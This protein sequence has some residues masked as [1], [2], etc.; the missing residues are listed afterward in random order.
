MSTGDTD[1]IWCANNS[2]FISSRFFWLDPYHLITKVFDASIFWRSDKRD[3]P[4]LCVFPI[5]KKFLVK[6]KYVISTRMA[7]SDFKYTLIV[8]VPDHYHTQ[9]LPSCRTPSFS[10]A[11]YLK[12]F[13][14]GNLY[15]LRSNFAI[16]VP[17]TYDFAEGWKSPFA[18]L[19]YRIPR[20]S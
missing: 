7:S 2:K 18:F 5:V 3:V 6:R 20:W 4:L 17:G 15:R 12:R 13:F 16:W 19:G 14:I 11:H 1:P 8:K 10:I 9:Q